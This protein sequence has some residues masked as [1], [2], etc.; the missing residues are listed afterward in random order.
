VEKAWCAYHLLMSDMAQ[1]ANILTHVRCG[2][3]AKAVQPSSGL[4]SVVCS[5]S[6]IIRGGIPNT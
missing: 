1:N 3:F 4:I 5:P 6:A 2:D